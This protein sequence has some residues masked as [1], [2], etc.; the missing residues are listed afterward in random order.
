MKHISKVLRVF[1]RVS[2]ATRSYSSQNVFFFQMQ[3]IYLVVRTV[4]SDASRFYIS[5]KIDILYNTFL[6]FSENL[7]QM[8]HISRALRMFISDAKHF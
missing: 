8:K 1:V 3:H 5:Q 6:E 4:I 2:D 7:Y